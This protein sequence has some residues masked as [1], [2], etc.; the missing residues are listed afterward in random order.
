[1]K[2]FMPRRLCA[3][4]FLLI[5]VSAAHA[6]DSAVYRINAGGP[7]STG[8]LGRVWTADSNFNT[9]N[10]YSVSNAIAGT[11]DDPLFQTERWDAAIAPKLQHSL[12]VANGKY[13]FNFY[14]AE[15]YS[16]NPAVGK[17]VFDVFMEGQLA[18]DNL[19]IFQ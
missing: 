17:R 18:Y 2:T 3:L 1:M 16:L 5:V 14:F 6:H 11:V 19:D 10:V 15:N 8:S 4:L 12:P 9:G 7:S 13:T